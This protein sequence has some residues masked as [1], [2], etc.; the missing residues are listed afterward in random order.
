MPG[1]GLMV[2]GRSEAARDLRWT[3]VAEVLFIGSHPQCGP[4]RPRRGRQDHPDRGPAAS[5]GSHRPARPGRGRRHRHR[6]RARGAQAQPVDL[7]RP[8]ADRVGRPQD[9]HHRLPRVRRLRRGGGGRPGGGRPGGVRGQR[10]RGRR[11]ADRA[12]VEGGR[13]PGSPPPDLRQQAR[14]GAG[15]LRAHPGA[16][17]ERPSAPAS[18]RSSCR[19]ARRPSFRGVADLLSDTAITYEGGQPHDRADPRRHGRPGA[20]RARRPGRGHRR[21]RRRPD[22][23]LPR[24]R[25]PERR[26]ARRRRWPRAW[27]SGPVFPVVCG[28]AVKEIAVD[29]LASFICEIGPS[30]LDRPPVQV[31][32]GGKTTEVAPGPR[33]AT[34]GVGVEDRRR[35]PRRQDQPVQGAVG[36]DQARRRPGQRPHPLRRA[37]PRPVHAARQG[38]AAG[39]G[40]AGRRPRRRRQARRRG[41]RRHPGAQ[42]DPGRRAGRPGAGA[43]AADRHPPEVEG[44]RGQADDRPAPPPG[45]GPGPRRRGATTRPTRRCSAGWARPTCRS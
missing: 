39:P 1:V 43:G 29:R 11:G 28:S 15:V 33:R 41:D 42:G 37:H 36:A 9:Q 5:L 31:E 12:H 32:A 45:G 10:G 27:P 2:D 7:G 16:P 20:H 6:F 4:G 44:R 14:P 38:A 8:G 17:A 35:S 19:S 25:G 21:R 24:G 30:P 23:A 22:G 13:R 40:A 34:A 26:A 18:P 3:A